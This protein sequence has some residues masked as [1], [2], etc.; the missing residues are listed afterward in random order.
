MKKLLL[1]LA[2]ISTPAVAA[3]S[4]ADLEAIAKVLEQ[5]PSRAPRSTRSFSRSCASRR[6]RSTA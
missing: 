4:S 1:A 5:T 6:R 2:L 3:T